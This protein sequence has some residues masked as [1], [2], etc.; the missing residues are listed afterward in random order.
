MIF[1]NISFLCVKTNT[2]VNLSINSSLPPPSTFTPQCKVVPK[3]L[4]TL[5]SDMFL[6]TGFYLID[7]DKN[8]LYGRQYIIQEKVKTNKSNCLLYFFHENQFVKL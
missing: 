7:T 1:W 6:L 5:N 8:Y 4:E 3:T 2:I